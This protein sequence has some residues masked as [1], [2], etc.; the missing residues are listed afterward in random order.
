MVGAVIDIVERTRLLNVPF[1]SALQRAR[2]LAALGLG[3]GLRAFRPRRHAARHHRRDANWSTERIAT[4]L[5]RAR[6]RS[7]PATI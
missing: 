6:S 2:G 7:R 1:A 3:H 4:L 5:S